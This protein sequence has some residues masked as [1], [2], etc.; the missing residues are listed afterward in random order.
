MELRMMCFLVYVRSSLHKSMTP[1][2]TPESTFLRQ[3]SC[4]IYVNVNVLNVNAL[5]IF[6]ENMICHYLI[7]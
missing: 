1:M 2:K 3:N 4:L 5:E 7:C 6:A